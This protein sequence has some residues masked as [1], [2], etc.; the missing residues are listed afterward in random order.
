VKIRKRA[1]LGVAFLAALTFVAGCQGSKSTPGGGGADN[2]ITKSASEELADAVRKLN[3]SSY[4]FETK[5]GSMGEKSGVADPVNKAV[6]MNLELSAQGVRINI[7]MVALGTDYYVKM[8]GLPLPG[9]D[10]S[11]YMHLDGTKISSLANLGIE[12]IVD[13]T[14]LEHLVEQFVTVEKSGDGTF[15]GTIDLT[16]APA[17]NQ[18][19]S[20]FGDKAKAAPFEATVDAEGRLTSLKAT[21]ST[22]DSMPEMEWTTTYSDFG[23]APKIE[24]PADSEITQAPPQLTAILGG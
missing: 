12:N 18:D 13:P 5:L 20:S 2:P 4:A 14:N 7:D 19:L 11:K 15:K 1:A 24:K 21:I 17:M 8:N 16:K 9:V 22:T 6:K 10:S 3:E 23:S